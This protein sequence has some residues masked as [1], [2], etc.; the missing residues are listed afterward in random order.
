MTQHQMWCRQKAFPHTDAAKRLADVYNLHR[1][2]APFDS[3]GKWIAVRLS[4]GSTDHTLYDTKRDAILHQHHNEQWY[5]FV[6][7][8]PTSMRE[9]EAEVMLSVHRKLYDNGLRMTDPDDK[10]GGKDVIKRVT[11]EDMHALSRGRATNLI[12]PRIER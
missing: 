2:G 11:A 5:V 4:D 9:C 12:L 8:V 6:K 1:V 10:H 3:I 7:I